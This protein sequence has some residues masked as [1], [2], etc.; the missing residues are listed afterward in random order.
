MP[1]ARRFTNRQVESVREAVTKAEEVVSD[2]FKLSSG[3][4]RY[5]VKTLAQLTADETVSGPMAQVIRTR[6]QRRGSCLVSHG[7][8]VYEICLQDHA[9]LDTLERNPELDLFAL[10]LYIVVHELIHIERFTRFKQN[11][12]ASA[13]ETLAEEARVHGLTREIIRELPMAGIEGVLH[14][15]SRWHGPIDALQTPEDAPP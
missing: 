7:Y 2:T 3:Q 6:K 14:F 11:F 1:R 10:V 8:D 5:D 13:E 4:W 9:I 12:E 15:F